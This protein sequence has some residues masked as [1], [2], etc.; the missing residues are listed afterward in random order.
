[1]TTRSLR[2]DPA[3]P[4]SAL[5]LVENLPVPFDRRVW[6]EAQALKRAGWRVA[7]ICPTGKGYDAEEEEIDGVAIYRHALPVEAE[8]ALDYLREYAAALWSQARLARKVWRRGRFDVIQACN[9]PD[10]MFLTA[11]P[12]KALRGVRFIFDHHDLSPELFETKFG[13]RGPL[14]RTLHWAVRTA[15]K[16]TFALAD[17]SIATNETFRDIAIAR[18]GMTAAAVRIVRSYPDLSR[19]RRTAPAPGLKEAGETLIG[20]LGV[21]GAQDGVD[22][23][24]RAMADLI[25][26]RGRTDLRCLIVGDG[27]ALAECKALAEALGVADRV[28]FTGF[29]SGED[30]LAHLCAMDLGV[31]P[32]PPNAFNDKLSMNKVFEYMALGL[33]FV[34]FDLAQ[35]HREAGEGSVVATPATPGGL[36]T[37]IADL[38]DDAGRRARLS[39]YGVRRAT[40]EFTWSSQEPELLAA[41]A[42]A[43]A[44]GKPSDNAAAA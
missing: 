38:A 26:R 5:I 37:A 20:Y 34:Q 13:L 12:Y 15:E 35:S 11:L 14:R 33:P 44:R 31:I 41:Y 23:L 18:G 17:A 4:P 19:F 32:D 27:P 3:R 28:R 43:L 16:L 2:G 29:L 40:A 9:P 22:I 24:V 25:D 6:Q 21:I 7:V 10:L 30:L 42:Y 36:A 1:M 8:G 39:E